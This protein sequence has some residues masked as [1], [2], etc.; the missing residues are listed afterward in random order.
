[1]RD[2]AL[3]D[4]RALGI[5]VVPVAAA[6]GRQRVPDAIELGARAA[7][8]EQDGFDPRREIIACVDVRQL[9]GDQLA[10]VADDDRD[11]VDDRELGAAGAA[12]QRAVD[13]VVVDAALDVG[14]VDRADGAG[15]P[16]RRADRPEAFEVAVAHAGREI[17][18][19]P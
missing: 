9:R 1:M 6:V 19:R 4:R 8:V 3:G 17:S 13:H 16:A 10:L 12:H 18:R 5:V 7:A 14:D 2:P 11:A 15:R